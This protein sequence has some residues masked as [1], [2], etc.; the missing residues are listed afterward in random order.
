MI[1]NLVVLW[2]AVLS[3]RGANVSCIVKAR[4]ANDNDKRGSPDSVQN[5][6]F[7][8]RRVA[9]AVIYRFGFAWL[10]SFCIHI[11]ARRLEGSRPLNRNVK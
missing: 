3:R 6:T 1:V 8:G 7:R 5:G 4:Q 11:S 10:L 9:I 2:L